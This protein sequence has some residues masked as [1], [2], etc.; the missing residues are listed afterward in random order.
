M[1][2]RDVRRRACTAAALALLVAFASI[3]G[4]SASN[5]AFK[6]NK[7][8]CQLGVSPTGQNLVS[9]PWN[10]PYKDPNGL[11]KICQACG[12]SASAQVTMWTGTGSVL[13]H[14]CTQIPQFTLQN[15]VGVMI[16]EPA[17]TRNCIFVGSDQPGKSITIQNLGVAPIGVNMFPVDY[18][19][20]A[21]TPQDLC[22]DCGLSNT[23]TISRFDACAGQVLVH[24]CGQLAQWNLVLGEAVMILENQGTR[25][26]NPSH[27]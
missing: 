1:A 7:Q 10:S 24:Q 5:M 26:C 13:V 4:A 9:L 14:N 15:G 22:A 6:I 16:T 12:L 18:H 21:V 2:M 3:S 17:A 20:T 27:F 25:V 23:A 19:T 8:V 11:D